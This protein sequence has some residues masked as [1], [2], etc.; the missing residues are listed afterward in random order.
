ML[1]W[2]LLDSLGL[3]CV[4]LGSLWFSWVSWVETRHP[5]SETS[6]VILGSLGFS[7]GS[8]RVLVGSR[9]LL[10]VGRVKRNGLPD[11]FYNHNSSNKHLVVVV[12]VRWVA[13]ARIGAQQIFCKLIAFLRRGVPARPDVPTPK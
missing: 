12:F 7:S 3:S 13:L 6:W 8:R 1:S 10:S 11:P 5:S 9:R 4:L 2:V